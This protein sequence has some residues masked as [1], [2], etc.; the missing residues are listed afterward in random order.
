VYPVGRPLSASTE[1]REFAVRPL[2]TAVAAS[3]LRRAAV[4]DPAGH[5]HRAFRG[6]GARCES[7]AGD[8]ARARL[9]ALDLLLARA[10][11]GA[12][13]VARL[14]AA[15]DLLGA[16]VDPVALDLAARRHRAH[17][18]LVASVGAADHAARHVRR[19]VDVL[20]ALVGAAAIDHAHAIDAIRTT[21]ATLRRADACVGHHVP[22]VGRRALT[23]RS[24]AGAEAILAHLPTTAVGRARA[25]DGAITQGG[26]VAAGRDQHGE[27][28]DSQACASR[29]AAV[30]RHVLVR[31]GT[32]RT[33]AVRRRAVGSI[34]PGDGPGSSRRSGR[35]ASRGTARADGSRCRS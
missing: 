4:S 5:H 23:A 29:A 28:E 34:A 21:R 9:L 3:G 22:C 15:V 8:V 35:C 16:R 14:H 10:R 30:P 26:R 27:D 6:F 1:C 7:G 24:R 20:R 18:L 11:S 32:S 25:R 17:D 2:F 19:T 33:D 12:A 13:D 31:S